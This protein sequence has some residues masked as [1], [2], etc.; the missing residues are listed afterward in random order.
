[1]TEKKSTLKGDLDGTILSHATFVA[2]AARVESRHVK[3]VYDFHL[4]PLFVA[5]TCRRVLK[6][7]LKAYDIFCV[8][9]VM[10]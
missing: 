9:C 1:M 6:H 3:I 7:V 2:R 10:S 4:F 8:V 5:T